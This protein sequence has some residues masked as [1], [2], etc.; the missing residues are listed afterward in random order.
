MSNVT[1]IEIIQTNHEISIFSID[2]GSYAAT[3]HDAPSRYAF[4]VSLFF[5]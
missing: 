4:D 1:D 5:H 3:A 2:S